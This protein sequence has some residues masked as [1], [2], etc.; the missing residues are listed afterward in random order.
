MDSWTSIVFDCTIQT[1]V[2]CDANKELPTT[3]SSHEVELSKVLPKP[4]GPRSSRVCAR[5]MVR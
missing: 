3:E 2:R 4:T 1:A 5:E